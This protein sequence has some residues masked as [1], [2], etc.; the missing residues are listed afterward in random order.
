MSSGPNKPHPSLAKLRD[1]LVNG[2]VDFAEVPIAE[3]NPEDIRVNF[4]HPKLNETWKIQ[5]PLF[6]GGAETGVHTI[7]DV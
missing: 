5:I 3:M 1:N 2:T 7:T 6:L 4:L